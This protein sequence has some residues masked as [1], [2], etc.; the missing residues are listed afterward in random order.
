MT[1][2]MILYGKYLCRHCERLRIFVRSRQGGLVSQNCVKCKK[3]QAVNIND[4]PDL[5]CGE[6][7]E[8]LVKFKRKNYFYSCDNCKVEWEFA[9]IVPDWYELFEYYGYAAP[10]SNEVTYTHTQ[11]KVPLSA[12]YSI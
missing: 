10:V 12:A 6:C 7:D 4:L 9:Q 5:Y 8:K 11:L 2:K 1:E 3:P